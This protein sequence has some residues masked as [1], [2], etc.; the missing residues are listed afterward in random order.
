LD[1]R[2]VFRLAAF[3]PA[4]HEGVGQGLKIYFR[5]GTTGWVPSGMRSFLRRLANVF[6]VD[7]QEARRKY[8]MLIG[9]KNLI[10]LMLAPF[11]IYVPIKTRNPLV[12]GDPTYGYFR[13]RSIFAVHP[14][15][16]PCT[17]FLEGN[18]ELTVIQS[19]RTV[20]NRLSTVRKL[21]AGL[22]EHYFNALELNVQSYSI[23]PKTSSML[24]TATIDS[25]T[26]PSYMLCNV[27]ERDVNACLMAVLR[28]ENDGCQCEQC[29]LEM[30]ALALNQLPP[31]YVVIDKK[32]NNDIRG[33]NDELVTAAVV[34]AV[35]AV[36][37][38]P[39]H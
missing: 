33:S 35:S 10:P 16:K 5:D 27:V 32:K 19:Y 20:K 26:I 3:T 7:L 30:A 38:N 15:P 22:M 18:H 25:A 9:Q 39:P 34:T 29:R 17:I 8:G 6:T 24:N 23:S 11:L 36:K 31:H 2:D 13:L 12:K 4:Y 28:A 37:N 14:E 1:T 21:E